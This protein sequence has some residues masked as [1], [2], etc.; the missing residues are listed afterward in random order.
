MHLAESKGSVREILNSDLVLPTRAGTKSPGC[1]CVT[2]AGQSWLVTAESRTWKVLTHNERLRNLLD[3][4]AP[5]FPHPHSGISYQSLPGG[6]WG[7]ATRL[8][9]GGQGREGGKKKKENFPYCFPS[10]FF[11]QHTGAAILEMTGVCRS[12]RMFTSSKALNYLWVYWS[13]QQSPNP[14]RLTLLLQTFSF[15]ANVNYLF[16]PSPA[17]FEAV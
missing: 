3:S 1:D 10:P 7:W 15:S 16:S 9:T 4:T 2:S 8:C 11:S 14:G 12:P 17:V 5:I 6:C 13:S